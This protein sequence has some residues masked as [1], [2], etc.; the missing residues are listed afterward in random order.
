MREKQSCRQQVNA[1][2]GQEVL[3]AQSRSSL[4]PRRGPGSVQEIWHPLRGTHRAGAEHG[5]EVTTQ[6]KWYGQTAAPI[7]CY[8]M[9]LREKERR[10]DGRKLVLVCF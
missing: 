8:T 7:P 9:M 3:H 6:T 4:W 1:G 5:H 10:V 2:G